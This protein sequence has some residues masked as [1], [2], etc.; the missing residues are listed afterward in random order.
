[1]KEAGSIFQPRFAIVLIVL[2]T[3]IFLL[4]AFGLTFG[5]PAATNSYT[6]A[7]ELGGDGDVAAGNVL[8]STALSLFTIVIFVTILMRT[9]LI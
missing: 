8:M 7:V 6:T 1:M 2:V 5:A 4:P 3:L 9:G